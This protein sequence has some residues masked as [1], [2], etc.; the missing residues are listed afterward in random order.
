MD[1]S[2][3]FPGEFKAFPE[4]LQIDISEVEELRV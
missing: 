3:T 1:A 2:E 4:D